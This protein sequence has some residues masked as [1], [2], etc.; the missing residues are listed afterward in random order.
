MVPPNCP[1][2]A[3]IYEAPTTP[4]SASRSLPNAFWIWRGDVTVGAAADLQ[5]AAFVMNVTVGQKP[6][7]TIRIAVD[8][9]AVVFVNGARMGS[10]GSVTDY[11]TA[12]RG[13]ST[14]A[15]IDLTPGLFPNYSNT[16]EVVCQNGPASFGNVCELNGCTYGENPAGVAFTGSLQWQ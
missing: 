11:N 1:S 13:Q 14:A 3:V 2:D 4:W 8:D 9:L 7:G 10:T 5:L 6:T 12:S 16:I 15:V